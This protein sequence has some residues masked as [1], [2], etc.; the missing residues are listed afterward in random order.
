MFPGPR[1]LTVRHEPQR[2][3]RPWG[4]AS[5]DALTCAYNLERVTGI[6]PALSAWEAVPS[7]PVTGPDP[8]D[9]VS[10]R[11]RERP[12]VT[13]VN[14]ANGP[15]NRGLACTDDRALALP[16]S[17]SIAAV[18]RPRQSSSEEDACPLHS[19]RPDARLP[20]ASP[21]AEGR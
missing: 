20:D 12:L 2:L 7:G 17:S 21:L 13:E 9:G 6:E 18:P 4:R 16:P 14:P 8:R 1:E 3:R 19:L 15:A 5:N 10:V 11:D